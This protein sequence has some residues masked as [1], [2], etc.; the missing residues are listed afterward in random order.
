MPSALH[1]LI[2]RGIERRQIFRHNNDRNNFLEWQSE[3]EPQTKTACYACEKGR[4]KILNVRHQKAHDMSPNIE[5]PGDIWGLHDFLTQERR[6]ID[7]KYD[8]RYSR[9]ILV[10]ARLMSEGWLKK[11]DLDGLKEDKISRIV[12]AANL[13]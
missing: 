11:E 10:F 13:L 2:I 1:H 9:L 3:L 5:S 8:Y 7:D 4:G 12:N 6:Q